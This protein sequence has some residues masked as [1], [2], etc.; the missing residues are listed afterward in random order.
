MTTAGDA[1]KAGDIEGAVAAAIATVKATPRDA[2]ARGLLA[3]M[4]LFAGE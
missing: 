2:G 3:E 4:L 1:F